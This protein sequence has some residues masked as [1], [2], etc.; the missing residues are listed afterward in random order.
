L[1]YV[2]NSERTKPVPNTPRIMEESTVT[3]DAEQNLD[4]RDIIRDDSAGDKVLLNNQQNAEAVIDQGS[5]HNVNS[6]GALTDE[7]QEHET[8]SG[9]DTTD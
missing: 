9:N 8:S 6:N 7:T 2:N 5:S 3:E 4:S 1:T